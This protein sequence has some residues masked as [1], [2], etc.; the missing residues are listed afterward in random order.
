MSWI[1]KNGGHQLWLT[2]F[3]EN[4]QFGSIVIWICKTESFRNSD[5]SFHLQ[6]RNGFGIFAHSWAWVCI[7]CWR[8]TSAQV[9][10]MIG[11][12]RSLHLNQF[13][14]GRW[15]TVYA[16]PFLRRHPGDF[17]EGL[18]KGRASQSA[19][20][21]S[22]NWVGVM[23]SGACKMEDQRLTDQRIVTS[24]MS[25]RRIQHTSRRARPELSDCAMEWLCLQT[26]L[27]DSWLIPVFCLGADVFIES[28]SRWASEYCPCSPFFLAVLPTWC[29]QDV[30]LPETQGPNETKRFPS[31]LFYMWS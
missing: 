13:K 18:M 4:C 20:V 5:C 3:A 17:S 2:W 11:F 10:I 28:V 19:Q 6:L 9:M 1:S 27:P 8:T 30:F 16:I 15:Y 29:F 12:C 23:L 7:I 26:M 31:K 22:G 24:G 21:A 25:V 14:K